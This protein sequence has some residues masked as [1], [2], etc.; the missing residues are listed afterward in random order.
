MK[1]NKKQKVEDEFDDS[2]DQDEPEDLP[3][4]TPMVQQPAQAVET[5]EI[6]LM[7]QKLRELKAV[8][9][10]KNMIDDFPIWKEH[11]E[12]DLIQ[13]NGYLAKIHPILTLHNQKFK[14]LESKKK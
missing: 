8:E 2:K 11:I 12:R 13:I 3:A 10:R 4:P 6:E 1:K 5:S 7:E 14:E 9:L